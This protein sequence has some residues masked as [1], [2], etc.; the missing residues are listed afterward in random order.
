MLDA[1]TGDAHMIRSRFQSRVALFF[2]VVAC[3]AGS[4][5]LVAEEAAKAVPVSFNFQVKPVLAGK[6]FACHGPDEAKRKGKLRL[7]VRESALERNAF[8][9]GNPDE[10]ELIAR[11]FSTDSDEV[12]PPP[13]ALHQL[14]AEE[15]ELLRRW[16]Q[17]GANYE[18]HWAFVPP[19]RPAVAGEASGSAAID[20]LVAESLRPLGI[21]PSAPAL[22]E[23]WLRRVTFD[24]NGLPPTVEELDGFLR[25]HEADPAKA[26]A[27][28]FDRLLASPRFGERLASE[29]LDAARYADTFGRHE[30]ADVAVW[31]Y[32][33]WVIRAFNDNMPYDRFLLWQTA[34]DLVSDASRDSR[35]ATLFNRLVPQSN[36]A[37]SNEEEF[38]QEHVADRVKT[39]ASA[40]LGLTME[41]ARCHDHKYDPFTMR[42]YYSMAA[43]LDNIDE[44][45]LFARF[46]A[47]VPAPSMLLMTPEAEKR[48]RE[49]EKAIAAAEDELAALQA[50]SPPADLERWIAEKGAPPRA[51]PVARYDFENVADKKKSLRKVF[52]NLENPALGEGKS[53]ATVEPADGP[54]GL[55]LQIDRDN[56]I[57]FADVG[58]RWRRSDPFSFSFWLKPGKRQERGVLL[59]RSRA[60]LDAA[61]RGYEVL[62]NDL[63]V[64]FSLS[65]FAP[66]NSIRVR[67]RE[68][69]P[70]DAWTHLV[71]AYDGSSQASGLTIFVN[72][73]AAEVEV[74]SDSLYR[75]ILYRKEWGDFDEAK[76][77]DNAADEVRLT[78]G[79]RRNDKTIEG[80]LLDELQVYEQ[81]LTA[82]EARA[83][84]DEMKAWQ[85]D[86]ARSGFG[87]WWHRL[88]DSGPPEPLGVDWLAVWLRDHDERGRELLADLHRLRTELDDLANDA[89]EIMVMRESKTRRVTRVL[90]RGRYDQPGDPVA[91]VMPAAVLPWRE[92]FPPNRLGLAQWYVD[93]ENPLTARVFVNRMWQ[94]FFGSGLVDTPEDFGT[95]G[96]LPSHPELL[97]WLAVDF[98]ESG[99]DIRRLCR[100]IVLS[101]TYG[102]SS[103]PA[104]PRLLADDPQNRQLARGPR[105]RLTA[106]MV[107]DQALAVGG[108]LSLRM[109]GPPVRPWQPESLY[110][111]SGIQMSYRPDTGES[112]WRRAVYTY[113]KRTMPPPALSVFDAPTREFCRVRRIQTDTPLQALALMNHPDYLAACRVLAER[114]VEEFPGEAAAEPRLAKAFR[115][116]TSR[117]ARAE[118][119]AVLTKLIEAERAHFVAQP[120]AASALLAP[121]DAAPLKANLPAAE[122][123]ATTL[124]LRVL[125][126]HDECQV[127]P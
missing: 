47:A 108:L 125:M 62:V 98:R 51:K 29:W 79:H 43:F 34:G 85:A 99:W 8:Q 105:Q 5:P 91:P 123:A 76:L 18:P 90:S 80:A 16:V 84:F 44:L 4:L 89:D 45:G 110:E 57:E 61:S 50:G 103:Q 106:E 127:K 119:I 6:C 101:Q 71:L 77:Q 41:C 97:D 83:I 24:L 59:H 22:P 13:D 86:Q 107:R 10:S 102:Q 92:S 48:T 15:K 3:L 33:D 81:T 11:I 31:P 117:A 87:R 111:D 113:W 64:E 65:H 36:E 9:P 115:L 70:L 30:D 82:V 120:D 60:G 118:E 72:G 100:Q 67:T 66:G 121:V 56:A 32:R 39:N 19:V 93:P 52:A 21:A 25:E 104:D 114:L 74:M 14:T 75:D 63:H 40:I 17:E 126:S 26:R 37:G 42:D 109:G 112:R 2:W 54:R 94:L 20:A 7:D 35:I 28:A 116:L 88:W 95:Q 12:M 58:M 124:A 55:A 96:A 38:R 69:L 46:T 49:L 122:V 73:E 78:I 1:A 23:Q 53:K 68:E 27:D